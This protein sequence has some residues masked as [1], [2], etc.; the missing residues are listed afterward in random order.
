M[1][2]PH[3]RV[4]EGQPKGVESF[5]WFR[6]QEQAPRFARRA[7]FVEEAV[8]A[9][10]R[11]VFEWPEASKDGDLTCSGVLSAGSLA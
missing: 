5:L 9:G 2:L 11:C 6:A 4:S 8:G 1:I 3:R 7:L 10:P